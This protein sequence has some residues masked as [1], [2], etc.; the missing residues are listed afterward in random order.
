MSKKVKSIINNE[1]YEFKGGFISYS[2]KTLTESY[3]TSEFT[4]KKK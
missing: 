1:Y 4:N 3:V 2:P